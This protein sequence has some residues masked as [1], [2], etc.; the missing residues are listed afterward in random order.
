MTPR[1]KDN[2]SKDDNKKSNFI[3]KNLIYLRCL[4]ESTLEEVSDFLGLSGKSS[5][6][7]Y[8]QEEAVPGIH[9]LLKL[10]SY[11]DVSLDELVRI[12]LRKQSQNEPVV[13]SMK[14]E[15]PIIPM[16]A[17][18]GYISGFQDENFIDSLETITV[19][20]KPYGIA[21]AFQIEGDSMEPEVT[22][23]A[24]VVGIK[25]DQNELQSGKNYV[26][27]TEDGDVVYKTVMVNSDHTLTLISRN[28]KYSP[29]VV[30]GGNIKEMWR[31]YCHVNRTE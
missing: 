21:R 28:V 20:Y 11:F 19:P 10:A 16:K 7:A 27:V 30:E 6:R 31:Y 15:V 17:R 14:H 29:K 9:I 25:I 22:D 12:D 26:V 13:F 1:K 2:S 24:Y 8:E 23:G 3:A 4:K 5:Y 18:A